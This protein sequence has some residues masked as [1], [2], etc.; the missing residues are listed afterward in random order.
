MKAAVIFMLVMVGAMVVTLAM[1]GDGSLSRA[2]STSA[3]TSLKFIPILLL[4]MFMVGAVD[5]L[6]PKALVEK[7][8]SDAAGL[9]GIGVA[10]IAGILTPAG[11]L[12]GLPIVAG[13][14]K[15]GVSAAVLVTYL[16][17]LATLSVVRVPME[18]G[19][20][21][22]KLTAIRV[23]ACLFLPPIAGLLVRATQPLWQ[24]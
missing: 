22:A 11:S 13:L 2:M 19:L 7:W 6:L 18:I 4:A 9:K 23:A 3:S 17:S 5:E 12:V 10:W 21:G 1:R 8:L 20:I 15:A 16:V 14:A 24:R